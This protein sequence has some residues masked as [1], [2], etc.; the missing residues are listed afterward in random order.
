[1]HISNRRYT[2]R[3][4]R[5]D[6][7]FFTRVLVGLAGIASLVVAAWAMVLNEPDLFKRALLGGLATLVFPWE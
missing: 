6:V 2:W 4:F 1:M 7:L 3:H 5:W